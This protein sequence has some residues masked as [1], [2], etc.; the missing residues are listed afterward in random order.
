MPAHARP[1]YTAY[2]ALGANLPSAAGAPAATIRAALDQLAAIAPAELP[3]SASSL[4]AT[5]PV[6]SPEG[7]AQPTY[8]NAI[9]CLHTTLGPEPLLAALLAIEQSFG[10]IR[11]AP[12]GPRTLDLDL[13]M[14]DDIVLATAALILP[15][16]RFHERRFVLTPLSEVA[17]TLR[18]PT[19]G[20]TMAALLAEL[21][22]TGEQASSGV[23]QL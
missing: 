4:Y 5:E 12:N 7:L 23:R 19:L 9:A 8:I 2:I 10:R 16:P 14:L 6:G 13:L 1:L 22:D 15:H 20:R 11:S 17:P 3:L 18:H 21:P